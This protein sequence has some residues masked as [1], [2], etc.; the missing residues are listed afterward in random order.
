MI[1]DIQIFFIR[2]SQ[3]LYDRTLVKEMGILDLIVPQSI[4]LPEVGLFV[5]T[6]Y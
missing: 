2:P 6:K 1:F 4:C 3:A 5:I